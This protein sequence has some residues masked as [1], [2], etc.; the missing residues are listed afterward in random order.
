M[1]NDV[2][3]QKESSPGHLV[4]V[5][6]GEFRCLAYL[7]SRQVWRKWFN[8]EVLPKGVKILSDAPV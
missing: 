6:C 5:Q 4:W 7:D 3:V 1:K 2:E 8:D